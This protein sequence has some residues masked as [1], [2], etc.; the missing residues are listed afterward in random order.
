MKNAKHWLSVLLSIVVVFALALT[1]AMAAGAD[2]GSV[3]TVAVETVQSEV[4]AGDEV[5]L[6][7]SIANNPGFVV[8]DFTIKYDKVDLELKEVANGSF[9]GKVVGN[10]ETAK[11]NFTAD[12]NAAGDYTDDG[13]LFILKFTAKT[14][15]ADGAQVTLDTTTFKNAQNVKLNPTIVPG[16]INVTTGGGTTGG[17]T[18]GGSTTGGSTTGGGTTGGSTTGGSTTGGSTT[19]GSTTGGSTTGGSTTG[20]STTGGSTTGGSTTGGSTTGGS[21]TGGSTTGGST[22]GGSTTGGGTTGGG[23]TGGSETEECKHDWDEGKVTKEPTCTEK[24]EKTFTCT[25]C[26]A[27]KTE[28]IPALGHNMIAHA[29]K[30]ATFEAAGNKAYWS[31]DRCNKFFSDAEGKQEIA[32]NSWVIPMK[33]AVAQIG[34]QKYESLQDAL[35]AAKRGDTIIILKNPGEGSFDTKGTKNLTLKNSTGSDLAVKL[36]GKSVTVTP[37]GV[38]VN[39][40]SSGGGGGSS[41]VAPVVSDMPLLHTGS[42]GDA[43]RT[44]QEKLNSLGYNSGAVDGIFGANTRAAVL[45][46]QR[47]NGLVADGYVGK[48]T[49]GKLGVTMS[50]A[51]PVVANTSMPLICMGSRGD[52]VRTLQEKLNSLGYNSGA[53]DGIF[54]VNTRAAVLSYQKANGLVADGYV[55]KLTWGKLL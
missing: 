22:T 20:G 27:T 24:G 31:C 19:G 8:Y 15:C 34:D 13:V 46:F 52:A 5:T 47:A 2:N 33:E 51:S 40:T 25:K 44:L 43:V 10:V 3:A 41:Y 29:A 45:A 50:S 4:K 48:L 9:E 12:P 17:S 39:K 38:K 21:T 14:D 42:R 11:V 55:G 26:P 53:V 7:V 36:D 6:N 49:W 23:T 54:G 16:G 32:E 1:T 28:D 35:N 37:K 30:D 18:T